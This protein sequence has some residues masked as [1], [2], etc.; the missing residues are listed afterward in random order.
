M[1]FEIWYTI[2]GDPSFIAYFRYLFKNREKD[3]KLLKTCYKDSK[4]KGKPKG[5]VRR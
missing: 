3:I 5:E 2:S 1:A 4:T